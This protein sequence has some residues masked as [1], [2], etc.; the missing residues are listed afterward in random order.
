[1]KAFI[2]M[3]TAHNQHALTIAACLLWLVG[4]CAVMIG[5]AAINRQL[6]PL[7]WRLSRS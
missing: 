7:L 3:T 4:L 5:V 1:M 6:L 2:A